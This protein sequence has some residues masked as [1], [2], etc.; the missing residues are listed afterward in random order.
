MLCA[1]GRLPA[2]GRSGKLLPHPNPNLMKRQSLPL[3]IATQKRWSSTSSLNLG[4]A[5]MPARGILKCRSSASLDGGA[6]DEEDGHMD[7]DERRAAQAQARKRSTMEFE[8]W[9]A[10]KREE[11]E[12][13][14]RR[15]D[16]LA[17]AR[18]RKANDG[19]P[20]SM[21]AAAFVLMAARRFKKGGK[22]KHEE[23]VAEKDKVCLCLQDLEPATS[24]LACTLQCGARARARP[25]AGRLPCA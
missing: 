23:W 18:L 4:A 16:T 12:R 7:A 8:K 24:R 17:E 15:L 14:E 10:G 19:K 6:D 20:N 2:M 9:K 3:G 21:K 22:K 11:A 5:P 13:V 1:P 25:P